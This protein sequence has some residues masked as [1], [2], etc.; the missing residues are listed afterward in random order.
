MLFAPG[1]NTALFEKACNTST[2]GVVFD[3]E[4]A[5][6]ESEKA[7]ARANLAAV[8]PRLGRHGADLLVRVNNDPATLKLDI[9][10]IPAETRAILLPKTETIEDL[11]ALHGLVAAREV[12]LGLRPGSIGTVAQIESPAAIFN[13]PAIGK[14]P[15]V[16]GMALGSEDF[17]LA[18]GTAPSPT[19]L[20]LPAQ[21]ICMAAA[22]CQIMAF[23]IPFSIAA[24]RDAEGWTK[25]VAT[26]KAFGATG[27]LCIH[28]AQVHAINEAFS[29]TAAEI[30]WAEEV[31][32]AWGRSDEAQQGVSSID[33]QM[34]DRPVVRR[35]QILLERRRPT[36]KAQG[37]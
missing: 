35:A 22:A 24:Y 3:L 21:M 20:T 28:P 34:I 30:T 15:R 37:A 19:L 31:L 4:D 12:H 6:P 17:A 10:A 23:A 25:A 7:R 13:L 16:I 1:D 33:G 14:A 27:G 5:V 32:G 36:E 26:A 18:M 29:P 11:L 2:D 8:A 9:A